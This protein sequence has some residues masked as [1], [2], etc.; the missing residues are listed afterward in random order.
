MHVVYKVGSIPTG[1]TKRKAEGCNYLSQLAQLVRAPARAGGYR[2]ESCTVVVNTES[3][4]RFCMSS[5]L[6][7]YR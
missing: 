1:V 5:N 7:I 6:T 4:K 2:F 3:S